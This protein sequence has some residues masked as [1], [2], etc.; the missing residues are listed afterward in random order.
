MWQSSSRLVRAL[1]DLLRRARPAA[2]WPQG[3]SADIPLAGAVKSC[4][5]LARGGVPPPA[6]GPAAAEGRRQQQRPACPLPSGT[7]HHGFACERSSIRTITHTILLRRAASAGRRWRRRRG[8]PTP[9]LRPFGCWPWRPA[10]QHANQV[11]AAAHPA[12]RCWHQL[13]QRARAAGRGM[14]AAG[15]TCRART[16]RHRRSAPHRSPLQATSSSTW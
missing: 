10:R 6:G 4:G 8:S 2:A 11:T 13:L 1:A 16:A 5:W 3:E 7:W 12:L 15:R 9:C 14:H